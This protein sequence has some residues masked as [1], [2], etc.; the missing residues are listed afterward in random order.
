MDK[1]IKYSFKDFEAVFMY[2]NESN[3]WFF[4][5]SDKL[6]LSEED[7]REVAKILEVFNK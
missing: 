5:N 4:H 7:L 2:D 3:K 6:V 1:K